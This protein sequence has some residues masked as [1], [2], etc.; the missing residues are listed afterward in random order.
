MRLFFIAT[1]FFCI[2]HLHGQCNLQ[3]IDTTHVNCFGESTGS[4]LLDV[5]AQSPYSISLNTGESYI[6]GSGFSNLIAGN[7]EIVLVDDLQCTDTLQIKIKEPSKLIADIR[8]EGTNLEVYVDGGVKNYTIYWRDELAQLLSNQSVIPFQPNTFYDFEVIDSKGC[9]ATDTVNVVADFSVDNTVGEYPHTVSIYNN[10]SSSNSFSW[11]FGDGNSSSSM[12]P[13]HSYERVGNYM[14]ELTVED[15]HGCKDM[16]S[17]S[18]DVQGFELSTNDWK[19]M[20]NAFSPN[21]DGVND[22]FSFLE[23]HAIVEFK[24]HI[25]SRWGSLVYTWTNPKDGWKGLDNNGNKLVQ[26]VYYYHMQA[27][28]LNGKEYIKKGAINLF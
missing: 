17:V 1:T 15:E 14:L 26:G 27:I 3:I 16:S 6:D 23:N 10:S 28:G 22:E 7:Y 9:Y 12:N 4:I 20:V 18:I 2:Q 19:E 5:M 11:D 25:F 21:G 24:T 13:V 8:C